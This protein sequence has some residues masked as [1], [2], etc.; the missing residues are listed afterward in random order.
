MVKEHSELCPF[1]D[2]KCSVHCRA[3]VPE[4]L[5][6]PEKCPECGHDMIETN[7]YVNLRRGDTARPP[8]GSHLD[9]V[10][11]ASSEYRLVETSFYCGHCKHHPSWRDGDSFP[12]GARSYLPK[13]VL[14]SGY[15]KRMDDGPRRA[16]LNPDE[17]DEY[18]K[19]GP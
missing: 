8:A 13:A 4:K 1:F 16:E 10:M 12:T 15:C 5:V 3:W 7:E 2:R 18:L 11:K 17:L 9:L 14:Y 19:E 6:Y